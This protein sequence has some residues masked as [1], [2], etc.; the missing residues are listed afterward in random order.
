MTL[1]VFHVV[2]VLNIPCSLLINPMKLNLM[3]IPFIYIY[4]SVLSQS[5]RRSVLKL[6]QRMNEYFCSGICASSARKWDVVHIGNLAD[7]MKIMARKIVDDPNEAPGYV[8]SASTCVW[9]PVPRQRVF[10]F[11][12]NE[13]LRG[14]WDMLSKGGPM[15][16]MLHVPKGQEH[17]NCVSILHVSAFN[18]VIF[19]CYNVSFKNI[20]L[21]CFV[22]SMLIMRATC[23][24]CKNH[25]P[26]HLGQWWCTLQSTCSL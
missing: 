23:C 6:A 14:E 10:D 25:G 26:M 21:Y 18:K 22:C 7:D 11:L 5:N 4:I 12:R 15:K 20:L 1:Q 2:T 19:M 13:Q 8:L 24:I 17:G 3:D 16:E 9:L